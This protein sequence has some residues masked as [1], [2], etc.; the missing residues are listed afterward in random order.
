MMN[1]PLQTSLTWL[2]VLALLLPLLAFAGTTGKIVGKV[3]DDKTGE[4]LPGVNVV[5]EGTMLGAV[6]DYDGDLMI[7]N[8]PPGTYTMQVKMIGYQP[9]SVSNVKV[10]VDM[11][12]TI[13][14]SLSQT[15]VD[16]GEQV[17]VVAERPIVQKD[18]TSSMAAV[19]SD[20][21]SAMPVQEVADVLELQAGLVRDGVGG[22]HVRGGRSGE[23]AYW[24]DGIA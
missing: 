17:T 7:I 4:T 23:V 16:V 6:T 11:T 8:V 15:V 24:V 1:K 22:I 18:K 5:L 21:I 20:E 13:N 3:K 12:T 9:K 19:S 2:A 14:V 10:S